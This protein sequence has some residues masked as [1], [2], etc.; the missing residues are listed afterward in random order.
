[1]SIN[2]KGLGRGLD[3][4][5]NGSPNA[6]PDSPLINVRVDALEPNPFQP[7]SSISDESVKELADSIRAQGMLQPVLVRPGSREGSYQIIAGERRWRA[8]SLAGLAEIPAITKTM[9]D[10]EAMLAALIENIQRNNLDPIDEATGLMKIKEKLD[11]PVEELAEKV[12]R[13]KSAVS[14]SLR[15]LQLDEESRKAIREGILSPSHGRALLVIEDP[16]ARADLRNHIIEEAIT[17]R[18]AEKIANVWNNDRRFPWQDEKTTT[19][20]KESM[21]P[22]PEIKKLAK[23]IGSRLNCRAKI[24]GNADKGRISLA[25][26]SNAEL[27]NLLDK[28]GLS[29][30]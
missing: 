8:A 27:F 12:G 28:L 20:P 18:D 29:L 17:T 22:D 25:Y 3:A 11:I 15:L 23:E 14:Y 21:R 13:S 26:E 10:A 16:E 19:R 2:N 24:N 7:R 1:M 9:D 6:A 30:N 4:L 5:F